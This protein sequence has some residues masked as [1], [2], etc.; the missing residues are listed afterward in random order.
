[1]IVPQRC[2]IGEDALQGPSGTAGSSVLSASTVF[3]TSQT[4]RRSEEALANVQVV[5]FVVLA[6]DVKRGRRDPAT[7][8]Q[9]LGDQLKSKKG[10]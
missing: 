10:I 4:R 9:V 3:S 6:A 7:I 5:A 2:E 8:M 1:V